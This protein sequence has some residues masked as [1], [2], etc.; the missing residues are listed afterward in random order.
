MTE[1]I[2]YNIIIYIRMLSIEE[3]NRRKRR[4]MTM[5][6]STM[7]W[8][9]LCIEGKSEEFARLNRERRQSDPNLRLSEVVLTKTMLN[10]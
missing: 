7:E 5:A 10:N 2:D 3:L 4:A 8:S 6:T 1:I 9:Y